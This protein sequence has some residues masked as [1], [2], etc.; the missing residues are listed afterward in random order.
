MVNTFGNW[1]FGKWVIEKALGNL[2]REARSNYPITK[3]PNHQI[4]FTE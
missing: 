2:A 4:R 3:L 1:E